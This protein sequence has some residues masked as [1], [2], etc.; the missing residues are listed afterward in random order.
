M[1]A[2]FL[3]GG[4]LSLTALSLIAPF[5]KAGL[6]ELPG[7]RVAHRRDCP[8]PG[9]LSC[10]QEVDDAL[11]AIGAAAIERASVPGRRL[12]P[13]ALRASGASSALP[14]GRSR[15]AIPRWHAGTIQQ[16]S[17]ILRL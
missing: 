13:S 12:T 15:L 16:K 5:S 9:I 7:S 1:L 2:K 11:D 4:L 10:I 6:R 3:V 14:A 17:P 8:E